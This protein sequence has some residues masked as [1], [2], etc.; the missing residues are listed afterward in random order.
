MSEVAE[1]WKHIDKHREQISAIEKDVSGIS[2]RMT[3]LETSF[4]N[5]A[6]QTAQGQARIETKI[7][8]VQKSLQDLHS[9]NSYE[10]GLETA[11]K[12]QKTLIK[13]FVGLVV[14]LITSGIIVIN[15][16]PK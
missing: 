7:E 4:Q 11:R 10:S 3:V 12:E 2:G 13:W 1:V 16:V 15:Y 14:T 6:S 9:K 5:H 8:C